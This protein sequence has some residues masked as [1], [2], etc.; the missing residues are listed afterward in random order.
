MLLPVSIMMIL[1]SLEKTLALMAMYSI[2]P[3]AAYLGYQQYFMM[4]KSDISYLN[5][6]PTPSENEIITLD[7]FLKEKLVILKPGITLQAGVED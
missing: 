5:Q 1:Q 6:V 4:N 3:V 7:N 2:I